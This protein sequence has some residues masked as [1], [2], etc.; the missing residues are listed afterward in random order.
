MCF[1]V[2][3]EAMTENLLSVP[4]FALYTSSLELKSCIATGFYDVVRAGINARIVVQKCHFADCG[5]TG[6]TAVNPK[7]VH[8]AHSSV[9]KAS[10]GGVIVKWLSNSSERETT[11]RVVVEQSEFDAN[12]HNAVEVSSEAFSAHNVAVSVLRN[13]IVNNKRDGVVVSNMAIAHCE[14][15]RNTVSSNQ[16]S[17][18]WV[19]SLHQKSNK[20]GFSIAD[21]SV[22][23]S[24]A[25]FGIY[26]HDSGFSVSGCEVETSKEEGICVSQQPRPD[27][28]SSELLAFLEKFPMRVTLN[29][30]TVKKNVGNGI[31]VQDCWKGPVDIVDCVVRENY[32]NGVYLSAQGRS[33]LDVKSRKRDV[34]PAAH[35]LGVVTLRGGEVANNKK[36]GVALFKVLCVVEDTEFAGNE[37]FALFLPSSES[38]HFLRLN[39]QNLKK[40]VKGDIGG[41]WGN[42][43]TQYRGLCSP[44]PQ[45]ALL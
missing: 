13:K 30:C 1:W 12:G 16:G 14:I 15:A 11:R 39:S 7:L 22:S 34:V 19:S 10:R 35:L 23:Y 8:V 36:N 4:E 3:G 24:L 37:E 45:C 42:V 9:T 6:L 38:R 2:N 43:Y 21:N 26:V 17:G 41:N 25:G 44:N 29:A 18:I 28:L 40:T 32:D 33:Q 31:L 5:N 27:H 20:P